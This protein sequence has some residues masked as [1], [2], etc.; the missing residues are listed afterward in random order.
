MRPRQSMGGGIGLLLLVMVL[1][2]MF[3]VHTQ[4]LQQ[5]TT[6]NFP[7]FEKML[8]DGQIS[9][10]VIR[11]NREI[12]TGEIEIVTKTGERR[13]FSALDTGEVEQMLRDSGTEYR[14]AALRQEN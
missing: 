14:T 11:P 7:Q 9:S 5:D 2:M 10:V 13:T 8:S 1:F 3:S 12:P 6:V 4:R